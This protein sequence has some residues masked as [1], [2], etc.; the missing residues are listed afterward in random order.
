MI[1]SNSFQQIQ[2]AQNTAIALG[3]FDGVHKGHQKVIWEAVR[4]A[5]QGLAPSVFTYSIHG[6][7]PKAKKNFAQI[8]GDDE[9]LQVL[10]RMG[11]EYVLQPPFEEFCNVSPQDFAQKL[12]VEQMRAKAVCC[13]EDFRFGRNAAGTVQDLKTFLEPFG[14]QVTIVKPELL[15]GKVISSTNVRACIKEGKMDAAQELLGRYYSINFPVEQGRQLGRQLHFPTINQKYPP[16]Y[17]VPCYGVYV[18]VT[19][20]GD[21]LYPS[22]SNVGVK[23]TVG[24]SGPLS[25]TFILNFAGD[26]YGQKIQVWFCEFIRGECKFSSIGQLQE[27]IAMDTAKAVE[28]GPYYAQRLAGEPSFAVSPWHKEKI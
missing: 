21:K 20:V 1:I 17:V 16:G 4:F 9:K 7:T 22:I 2:P 10:Q 13:G 12:L 27:Q 3:L 14:V 23:P 28:R 25:E 19:K 18:S 15:K 6:H 11:V 24:A 5:S 26:L 8:M